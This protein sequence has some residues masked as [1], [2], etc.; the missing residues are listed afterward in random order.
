MS[1]RKWGFEQLA[2]HPHVPHERSKINEEFYVDGQDVFNVRV[3]NAQY[4]VCIEFVSEEARYRIYPEEI[5]KLLNKFY[6][7]AVITKRRK[8]AHLEDSVLKG[9]K[10]K[11]T[12]EILSA[13]ETRRIRHKLLK[14]VGEEPYL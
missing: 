14:S 12:K 5:L 6:F 2:R 7:K 3:V 10:R 4:N 9:R 8:Y 1:K 11:E 13:M